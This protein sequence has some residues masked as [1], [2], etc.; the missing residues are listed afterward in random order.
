[1]HWVFFFS[2]CT[3]YFLSFRLFEDVILVCE[4]CKG[5]HETNNET[6]PGYDANQQAICFKGHLCVMSNMYPCSVYYK[7]RCFHSSEHAYQWEKALGVEAFHIACQIIEAQDGY[8]AKQ[9]SALLDKDLVDLWRCQHAVRIM[10]TIAQAK[11]DSVEE[12]RKELIDSAGMYLIEATMDTYW[13]V[14]FLRDVAAYCRPQYWPG[15]NVMGRILMEIRDKHLG[16]SEVLLP[17][18]EIGSKVRSSLERFDPLDT[19]II[20]Y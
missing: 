9:I 18:E 3:R 17:Y 8:A 6:C 13:G 12:F 15:E 4:V 2:N 16:Q 7:N 1:M 14:G 19:D 11:F 10:K 20:Q 5:N